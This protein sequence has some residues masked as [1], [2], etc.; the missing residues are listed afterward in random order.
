MSEKDTT[1]NKE[2]GGLTVLLQCNI[3]MAYKI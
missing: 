3:V 2:T 1:E